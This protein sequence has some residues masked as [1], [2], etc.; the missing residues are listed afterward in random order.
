MNKIASRA[1]FVS[2]TLF[3]LLLSSPL[4][5]ENLFW[6]KN[7]FS[8]E[9]PGWQNSMIF[10][11]NDKGYEP[12]E[13]LFEK[14]PFISGY[15]AI[16]LR[17]SSL[18]DQLA[19][20]SGVKGGMIIDNSLVL[21]ISGYGLIAPELTGKNGQ[22][23]G[24]GYGGFL[25]EYIFFPK[26]MFH[27]SAGTLIGGGNNNGSSSFFIIEPETNLFI[28]ITEF[29]KLGISLSYRFTSGLTTPVTGQ[30]FDNFSAG[31]VFAFGKF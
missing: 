18:Y 15:G 29:F 22:K 26:K 24:L 28:H 17:F 31:L 25:M 2:A 23:A 16:S 13:S 14:D 19:V 10:Q 30:A 21:G 6:G 4:F 1:A 7:L 9:T 3:I 8:Q 12:P 27:F 5:A 20:F 11:Q